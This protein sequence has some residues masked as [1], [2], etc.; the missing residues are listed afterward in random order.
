MSQLAY[1]FALVLACV[2]GT[3]VAYSAGRSGRANGAWPL[4]GMAVASVLWA[5]GTLGMIA[6]SEPVAKLRWLQF[7]YLGISTAPVAFF[8][9]ALEYTGFQ[10]YVTAP[11]VSGL[12]GL[13]GLVVGLTWTNPLHNYYWASIAYTS[14]VPSGVSTSPEM[15]FWGFVVMTYVLLGVGSFL[16]IRYAL[17]APHLYRS[18]SVVIL[19]AV[20]TPWAANVPHALQLMAAD[21]TPVALAVTTGGFWAAMRRYR[22]TDLSPIAL[23]TIFE[24]IQAGVIV[25]DRNRRVAD[26]NTAAQDLLGH[27]GSPIGQPLRALVSSALEAQIH[28]LDAGDTLVVL[29]EEL[30]PED[31][32]A[33]STRPGLDARHIEVRVTPIKTASGRQEGRLIVFSDVTER[34]RRQRQLKRKNEQLE[35][36]A[37]VVSHDLRTPLNVAAGNLTLAQEALEESPS[38]GPNASP[39]DEPA[40]GAFLD[41]A[42]RALDRM[43]TL[44]DDLLA[45]A[46]GGADL[47]DAEPVALSTVATE[48]WETV[49]T[50]EAA[51]QTDTTATVHADRSRLLQLLENLFHNAVQHGGASVTVTVGDRPGGFYVADDGPG[52]SDTDREPSDADRAQALE[53]GYTTRE[54]GTGFGLSIV[55]EIAEAHGWSIQLRSATTGGARIDVTGVADSPHP[56]PDTSA[57]THARASASTSPKGAA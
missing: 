42:G 27:E 2:F 39:D 57:D 49:D 21:Y 46:T 11:T 18:Q 10:R 8:L 28:D 22:L 41:R 47:A 13:S 45:L 6:S 52:F 4:L 25:L 38:N 53:A 54:D 44:I 14:A 23:R 32:R 33:A 48:A 37:S 43:E 36:F 35:K 55:R 50:R 9:F 56:Q 31:V 51:L 17:I 20:A 16:L 7:S 29:A 15:G 34:Q 26:A 3:G 40:P 1:N 30:R 5:V 24:S 12:L 19:V